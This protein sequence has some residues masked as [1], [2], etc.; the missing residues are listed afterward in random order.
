MIS[1]QA[2]DRIR[3]GRRVRIACA[4][5]AVTVSVPV[6]GGSPASGPCWLDEAQPRSWNQPALEI[7]AAP[8]GQ[9]EV[10]PRCR[11][12]ARPAELEEDKRLRDRGWDLVGDF[13]GGWQIRI[14]LGTAGYDGMCRPRQYQGFVFVHGVFAGTLSP[15]AM[16]SRT[17]GALDQVHLQGDGRLSADY[18]R[19]APTDPLC[20]PS[21]T[22]SVAFEIANGTPVLRPVSAS[23]SSH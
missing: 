21:R 23:T 17:D 3:A 18:R 22:T 15:H 19:Y 9:D 2:A 8:T 1:M 5:G 16:D 12:L 13:Q 4:L 10:D 20:C 11:A 7:P 14:I 6:I